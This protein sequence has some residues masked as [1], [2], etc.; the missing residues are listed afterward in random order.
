MRRLA[1]LAAILAGL[2]V[3]ASAALADDGNSDGDYV[4]RAY[5]DN[6]SFTVDGQDVRVGGANVGVIESV[7]VSLPGEQVSYEEGEEVQPGTALV[8]LKI[9]DPG[10]KRFLADASC[11]LRPQSLIGERFVDCKTT[12]PRAATEDPPPELEQIPEGQP[13]E[14]QYLLPL[15][16]NGR[17]VDID[18]VNNVYREPFRDRFRL[19]LNEL[20]AGFATRGEDLQEIIERADPTLRE[21]NKVLAKLAAQRKTLQRLTRDSDRVLKPLSEARGDLVGWLRNT[22]VP[23][24]VTAQRTAQLEEALTLFPQFLRELRST[25]GEFDDFTTAAAPVL[26]E[27]G[28][29]APGLTKA[30]KAL[31]PFSEGSTTALKS[32]GRAGEE[33][34]PLFAEANPIVAKAGKLARS[35]QQPTRDLDAFLSS[36]EEPSLLNRDGFQ[37]L[38]R[39]IYN[40]GATVN[41]FDEYGTY[42][43]TY[44]LPDNCV[45]YLAVTNINCDETFNKDSFFRAPARSRS[46]DAPKEQKGE[47][48]SPADSGPEQAGPP[49]PEPAPEPEPTP[50]PA[51]DGAEQNAGEQATAKTRGSGRGIKDLLDYLIR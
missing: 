36:L 27:L 15:E 50:A 32:L 11:I 43:R 2:T 14:G 1:L 39:L 16:N 51:P 6:G 8:V 22:A 19:I 38:M 34:G 35:G 23:A 45:D 13:G 48:K 30:T 28:V 12:E 31:T 37:D 20:G 29:A 46:G 26:S 33:A 18:L 41:G 3:A 44:L 24:Q 47:K 4:V 9:Q 49:A 5:F 21:G 42:F 10:Y 25:M 7:D 17:T 40:T